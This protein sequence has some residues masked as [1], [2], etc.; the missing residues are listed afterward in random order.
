MFST[1]C[2]QRIGI[3]G[4]TL[5]DLKMTNKRAKQFFDENPQA[6]WYT[7]CRVVD[8]CQSRKWR[9]ARV[10]NVFDCVGFAFRDGFVPELSPSG[11]DADLEQEIE[12]ALTV[13]AREEWR[14]RLIV[15]QGAAARKVALEEW[16][17]DASAPNA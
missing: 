11:E 5:S 17:R 9:P 3:P 4:A 12:R 14:R 6:T 8:W 15:T 13:E 10:W 16:K 2:R 7:L 1:Y